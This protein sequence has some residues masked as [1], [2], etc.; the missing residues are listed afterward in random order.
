MSVS[1]PPAASPTAF[2]SPT[3]PALSVVVF[4]HNEAENIPSVLGQ[5]AQWLQQQPF[6]SEV[7]FVDDGSSDDSSA[8]AHKAL[9]PVPARFVRHRQRRGIGAALKSGVRHARAPWVTFLPA[10]GQIAPSALATLRAAA[11]DD[12]VELVCSVY[13]GRDDGWH[14]KILSGGVRLLITLTQGIVLDSDGP[15]LF[16]RCL[17][18]PAQLPPDSFF[19]NFEFPIRVRQAGLRCRTVTIDCHP[20]RAGRSKSARLS[21]VAKVAWELVA[22]RLRRQRRPR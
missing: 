10:D 13:R 8:C 7:I 11:L 5:L 18:D 16:R 14:R 6:A 12:D 19:L 17:F 9:A 15:Y 3:Q 2:R 1:K 20:R 21:V 4:A 22:L